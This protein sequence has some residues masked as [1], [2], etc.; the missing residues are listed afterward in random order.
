MIVAFSARDETPSGVDFIRW[1]VFAAATAACSRKESYGT[2][3]ARVWP[4]AAFPVFR[5]GS[6]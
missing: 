1:F 6:P 2:A 5:D 4:I 3:D